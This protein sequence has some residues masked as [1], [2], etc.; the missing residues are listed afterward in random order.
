MASIEL[1][2]ASVEI[3]IFNSRGRSLKTTLIRRVGGQVETD[4]RD[5]VTVQARFR[6]VLEPVIC[7]LGVYLFQSVTP[8][9]VRVDETKHL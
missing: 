6:H 9:R 2:D 1:V 5:A 3:P 4:G 8:R 7:V